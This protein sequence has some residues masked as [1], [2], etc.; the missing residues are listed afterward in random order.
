M[1]KMVNIVI[2]KG[3]NCRIKYTESP[4][5]SPLSAL[6]QYICRSPRGNSDSSLLDE[7]ITL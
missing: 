1:V 6:A 2:K 3:R 7:F 5:F 4:E